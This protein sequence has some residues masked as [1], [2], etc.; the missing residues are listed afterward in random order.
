AWC[1][2]H[3]ASNE[4]IHVTYHRIDL[5]RDGGGRRHWPTVLKE[6]I[7]MAALEKDASVAAVARQ[8]DVDP[9][10]I[11]R[12]IRKLRLDAQDQGPTFLPVAVSPEIEPHEGPGRDRDVAADAR[13]SE[14]QR[15]VE[16]ELS[17]NRVIRI[18]AEID[19]RALARILEVVDR[20]GSPPA[21]SKTRTGE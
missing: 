12:W 17:G 6:E 10:S 11:Y 9:S 8:H 15:C 19:A 1:G 18:D 21:S 4:D 2:D 5:V 14:R 16:I 3:G 20:L 13:S 7:V